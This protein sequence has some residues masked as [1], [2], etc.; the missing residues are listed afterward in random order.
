MFK[1]RKFIALILATCLANQAV[2]ES[3]EQVILTVSG[4]GDSIEYTLS[5]LTAMESSTFETST[6][7]SEGVL[8]FTGVALHTLLDEL[9]VSDGRL[10]ARAINDYAVEIP[11]S[12]GVEGGPILAYMLNDETMSVRNK[13][14]LWLVYPFDTN[15]EYRSEVIYSRSI[16]QLDRIEV[17]P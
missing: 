5:D 17:L 14:P 2:A 15:P 12:D 8:K 16:W 11:V 7:W 10:M 13:G 4:L 3:H 6:I 9:G 1:R